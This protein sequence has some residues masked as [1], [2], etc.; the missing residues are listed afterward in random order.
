MDKLIYLKL[1]IPGWGF[2][3]LI[4]LALSAVFFYY[5]QTIPPLIPWRRW[6][7]GSLRSFFLLAAL[8]LIFDGTLVFVKKISKPPLIAVL[9]DNS[10]SMQVEDN[11]MPRWETVKKIARWIARAD[12]FQIRFWAFGEHARSLTPDSLTFT[13]NHTDIAGALETVK[14]RLDDQNL[15]AVVLAS[16]GIDNAGDDPLSVARQFPLPI[17]TVLVGDTTVPRDI[18]LES[19]RM[20]PVI[21][22]NTPTEVEVVFR[23]HGFSGAR[24]RV[25]V[26]HGGKVLAT[27]RVV[28]GKDD[29]QQKVMLNMTPPEAGFQR[30]VIR[31]SPLKGETQMRN[32]EKHQVVRVLKDRYNVVVFTGPPSFDRRALGVVARQL[33]LFHFAFFTEKRNGDFYEGP[34]KRTVLDSADA[35]IFLGYPSRNTSIATLQPIFTTVI[36]RR[37]PVFWLINKYLTT[38]K[39]QQLFPW[40]PFQM[41]KTEAFRGQ[42][43]TSIAT[44]SH[45]PFMLVGKSPQEAMEDWRSLPPVEIFSGFTPVNNATIYLY[46]A[47]RSQQPVPAFWIVRGKNKQAVLAV[48]DWGM[49]YFQLQDDP[50]RQQFF[51]IWMKNLLTWLINREDLNPVQIRPLQTSVNLGETVIFQGKVYDALFEEIPDAEVTIRIWNDSLTENYSARTLGNGFY[52]LEIPGL[53]VGDYRYEVV[54]KRSGQ[55]LGKTTGKFSV[56]PFHLEFLRTQAQATILRQLSYLTEGEFYLPDQLPDRFPLVARSQ[57]FYQRREV[58]LMNRWHWLPVLIFFLAMEWF[59]RK[60]WGLL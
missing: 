34:L 60:R 16:D 58:V 39:L 10:R 55:T 4:I 2:L 59:F 29:L 23:H 45:Q 50:R 28:L 32:N 8:L 54:A 6:L 33:P 37:L 13:E 47:N 15:V 35:L 53:T 52:R 18:I 3:F 12:S 25:M 43:T 24:T 22:K 42:V 38:E 41:Q 5:R 49:W 20:N 14:R 1:D 19:V 11:G 26:I 31:I 17:F 48:A 46:G 36:Q 9:L 56:I 51:S 30:F 44:I 27:T 7:L 57:T 40:V 21:R